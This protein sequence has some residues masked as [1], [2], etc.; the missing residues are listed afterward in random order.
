MASDEEHHLDSDGEHTHYSQHHQQALLQNLFFPRSRSQI[1]LPLHSSPGRRESFRRSGSRPE[2]AHRRSQALLQRE[3][4]PA[5][6]WDKYRKSDEELKSIKNRKVRGFYE[7][8]VR[9]LVSHVI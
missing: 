1:F 4:T 3:Q 9:L 8:Q 7:N 6:A 2:N 5:L